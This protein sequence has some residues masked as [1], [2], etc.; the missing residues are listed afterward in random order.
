MK[1]ILFWGIVL[2]VA[3]LLIFHV[4]RPRPLE[5]ETQPCSLRSIAAFTVEEG[6]TR[7]DDVYLVTMP[8]NGRLLRIELKEGEIVQ[9]DSVIAR[10][11]TFERLERLKALKYDR[12][13]ELYEE[14]YKTFDSKSVEIK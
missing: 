8:V 11:E 1:K 5:V 9:K 10:L 6:E 2:I 12:L 3:A 14:S 13:I 4:M 7:L